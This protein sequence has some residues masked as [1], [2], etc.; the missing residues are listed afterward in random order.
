MTP[1]Q[2]AVKGHLP[3]RHSGGYL[4]NSRCPLTHIRLFVMVAGIFQFLLLFRG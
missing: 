3:P 1:F 2:Q 4:E